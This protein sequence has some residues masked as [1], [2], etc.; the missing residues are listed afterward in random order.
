MWIHQFVSLYINKKGQV[1]IHSGCW[2][3]NTETRIIKH[4]VIS[5]K[6]RLYC[7]VSKVAVIISLVLSIAKC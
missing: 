5:D 4:G 1:R 6:Q 2:P 3:L 7:R